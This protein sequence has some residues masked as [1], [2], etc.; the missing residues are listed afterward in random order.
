[1]S[2]YK[3]TIPKLIKELKKMIKECLVIAGN[4]IDADMSDDKMH[5]VIKSKKM[6]AEQVIWASQEIDTLEAELNEDPKEVVKKEVTNYAEEL[7]D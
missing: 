6:A 2:Y 7:A 1:M 5:N 3:D 4:K